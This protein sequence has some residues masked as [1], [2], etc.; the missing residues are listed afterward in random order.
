MGKS[1][2]AAQ[3]V[4]RLG[5]SSLMVDYLRIALQSVTTPTSHP[6]LHSFLTYQRA[7]WLDSS[8]IVRDW[9]RVA[10]ALI[11]PLR[12][13]MAHHI[14]FERSGRLIIEGDGIIPALV[15]G[16]STPEGAM[17]AP[18]VWRTSVR[19]LFLVSSSPE[20]LSENLAR[21]LRGGDEYDQARH[22]AFVEA[23]WHYGQRIA[24]EAQR[25][26]MTVITSHPNMDPVDQVLPSIA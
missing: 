12:E 19:T 20:D 16:S 1:T 21:R 11:H 24:A 13:I 2:L 25:Q 7:D 22:R 26:Q 6:D 4:E 5:V 8:C 17:L 23:S 3:L 14:L 9:Y 10:H 15:A 18:F